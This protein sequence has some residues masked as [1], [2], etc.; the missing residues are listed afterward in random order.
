MEGAAYP[1]LTLVSAKVGST[2]TVTLLVKVTVTVEELVQ[3]VVLSVTAAPTT[4]ETGATSEKVVGLAEELWR[5][6]PVLPA[7]P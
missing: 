1:E 2:V 5:C 4:E 6:R 3:V 7:V